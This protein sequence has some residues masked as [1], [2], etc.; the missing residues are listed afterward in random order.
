LELRAFE[1]PPHER[2]SLAQQLLLRAL[3]ASF[4]D[5]PY[6]AK[7]AHYGTRLHDEFMLP[8]FCAEDFADVLDDLKRAGYAFDP[9]WFRAHHEFRFPVIGEVAYRGITLELRHALEP[10]HVLGEDSVAGGT[11]RSVDSSLER[12]QIKTVGLTEERYQVLCN[13]VRVPLRPTEMKSAYVAGVRFRAWQ[14][15][16]ALHPTLPVNTPLVFDIFDTWSQRAIG[17]CTYHVSHPGGRNFDRFP[18]N[19]NEAESRRRA[20]FFPFG[21]TGGTITPVDGR[22]AGEHPVTLDLRSAF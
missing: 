22:L 10:W 17:G 3:V 1:M 18:V 6:D 4:W 14:P 12:I 13:G 7:L 21:H 2:M 11:S 20:R 5:K 19:A 15:P 8:Y 9:E 16:R